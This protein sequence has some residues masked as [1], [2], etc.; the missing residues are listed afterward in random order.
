MKKKPMKHQGIVK[1]KIL[2]ATE[3]IKDYGWFVIEKLRLGTILVAG[4]VIS[5]IFLLVSFIIARDKKSEQ[6]L[7]SEN[8]DLKVE[9]AEL[10]NT[11]HVETTPLNDI[12][13]NH[14]DELT[15]S[16]ARYRDR[17]RQAPQFHPSK[18]GR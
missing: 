5:G 7:E 15:Q 4:L 6:E 18:R 12:I 17:P 10:E 14:N 2:Q 11:L 1:T 3:K 13:S 8:L 16:S 9:N